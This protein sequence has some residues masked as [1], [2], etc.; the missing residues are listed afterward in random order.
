MM[1]C[2]ENLLVFSE[3]NRGSK[4]AVLKQRR[5]HDPTTVSTMLKW[6]LII[7]ILFSSVVHAQSVQ[8][9]DSE[10]QL[11]SVLCRNPQEEARNELPLDKNSQLVNITLW[12]ALLDCASGE[13]QRSDTKS[14]EIYSLPFAS[15]I[16]LR[17]PS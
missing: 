14:T 8:T 9:I 17:N 1:L 5:T 2:E 16:N 15:L 4:L 11:A 3:K 13:S 6:S 12:K 7:L 10:A